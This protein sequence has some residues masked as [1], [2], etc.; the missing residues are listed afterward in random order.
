M[1]N[2]IKG[3]EKEMEVK[4]MVFL[5]ICPFCKKEIVSLSQSQASYNIKAHEI[6]CKMNPSNKDNVNK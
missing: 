5:E 4:R 2:N 6:V 3:G 1:K